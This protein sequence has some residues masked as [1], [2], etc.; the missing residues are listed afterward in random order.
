MK[1]NLQTITEFSTII[2]EK[3]MNNQTF[4]NKKIY[5]LEKSIIKLIRIEKCFSFKLKEAIK[6]EHN[7]KIEKKLMIEYSK[8]LKKDVKI[9]ILK[10]IEEI[11]EEGLFIRKILFKIESKNDKKII[12][13]RKT[14]KLS[15]TI[16]KQSILNINI[17]ISTTKIYSKFLISNIKKT[18]K[19]EDIYSIIIDR[20]VNHLS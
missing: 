8:I 19:L 7:K 14:I 20:K 13:K 1:I 11:T 4:L 18:I 17:H 9:K 2:F 5:K 15:E 6:I 3:Y 12:D 16:L 10:Q